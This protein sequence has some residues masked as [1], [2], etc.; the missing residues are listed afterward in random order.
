[1]CRFFVVVVVA[2]VRLG[3]MGEGHMRWCDMPLTN[4]HI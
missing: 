4:V 1:M 2:S 3:V